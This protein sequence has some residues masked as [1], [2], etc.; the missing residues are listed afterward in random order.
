MEVEIVSLQKAR[1]PVT[2]ESREERVS[3]L[4]QRFAE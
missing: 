4:D 2:C 1:K 3:C